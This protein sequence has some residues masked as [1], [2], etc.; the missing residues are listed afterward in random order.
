MTAARPPELAPSWMPRQRRRRIDRELRRL[1][2]LGVCSVCRTP[3]PNNTRTLSGLDAKGRVVV[4]G[5][6]CAARVADAFAAGV[7]LDHHYDFPTS[8]EPGD[9]D[10]AAAAEAIAA[11]QAF[12]AANDE[13]IAAI[14]RQGGIGDRR[15]RVSVGE[16]PWKED[17]RTWFASH[18]GRAHRVRRPFPGEADEELAVVPAGHA[19]MTVVRQVVPGSRVRLGF[20]LEVGLLPLPDDEGVG[21]ALFEI[22]MKRE[23][24]PPNWGA[25]A[26][27]IEKYSPE[28]GGPE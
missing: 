28:P 5:E 4:A 18:P 20:C 12:A 13:R 16:A 19:L 24:M 2:G 7:Y 17:D 25:L 11:V 26:D 6:C 3:F 1:L 27:L 8:D 21:H 15:C 14:E 10:P 22:G 23:P 9:V